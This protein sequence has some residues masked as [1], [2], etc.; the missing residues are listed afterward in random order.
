MRNYDSLKEWPLCRKLN[1]RFWPITNKFPSRQRSFN[2]AHNR[3]AGTAM[4][5]FGDTLIGQHRHEGAG[6]V[7]DDRRD[8]STTSELAKVSDYFWAVSR[9]VGR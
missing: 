4:K 5:D 6:I 1:S 9:T 2:F 8:C 7:S 3:R